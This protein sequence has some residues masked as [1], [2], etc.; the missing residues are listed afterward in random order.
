MK[1][2]HYFLSPLLLFTLS[3]CSGGGGGGGNGGPID[4]KPKTP[5]EALAKLSPAHKAN[6][7][8]WKNKIVKA[9]DSSSA[10]VNS[11]QGGLEQLGVDGAELIKANRN[12]AIFTLD[13]MNFAILSG[14]TGFSGEGTTK[15]EETTTVN[16]QSYTLQAETQREG[17]RCSLYLFGQKVH[18]TYIVEKFAVGAHYSEQDKELSTLSP[19]PIV[20]S[21]GTKSFGE[22]IRHG[23][24]D[25]LAQTMAPDKNVFSLMAK[26][27]NISEELAS[28]LFY[29]S[30]FNNTSAV[31]LATTPNS[32]WSS[33][34]F[35]NLIAPKSDLESVFSGSPQQIDLV[36][37]FRIPQFDFSGS[38]NSSDEG[39]LMLLLTAAVEKKSTEATFLYTLKH[40][41]H[42]G[43]VPYD[44]KEAE[45]CVNDRFNAY[46]FSASENKAILPS[47]PVLLGPCTTLLPGI[48]Q[49]SYNNGFFKAT[50]AKAFRMVRPTPEF[51]YGGWDEV[52]EL[53][54]VDALEQK[55]S[56]ISE[57]DPQQHT[58]VVPKIAAHLEELE[59]QLS[60][61]VNLLPSKNLIYDMGLSWVFTG[62]D[63]SAQKIKQILES[64][65]NVMD[66]FPQSGRKLMSSLMGNPD[67]YS[68][69]LSFA[70]GISLKYK[71]MALKTLALSKELNDQTFGSE[72]FNSVVQNQT[73]FQELEAWNNWFNQIKSEITK[74]PVLNPV[75]GEL[76][77]HSVKWLKNGEATPVDLQGIYAA[78]A[79]AVEPFADSTKK[80][81]SDLGQSLSAQAKALEYAQALTQEHRTLALNILANATAAEHE[82]LGR[83]LFNSI[84]QTQPT[85]AQLRLWNDLWQGING[86]VAREKARAADSISSRPKWNRDRIVEL[87]IKE[88]W[89][90]RNFLALEKIAFVA[91]AKSSCDRY[92][93][94]SSLADCAGLELFSQKTKKF[95][96]PAFSNRYD[97]LA[98]DFHK[99]M[100]R[101]KASEWFSLR[102]DLLREF[103]GP[104]EPIWS[105]CDNTIFASKATEL[106]GQVN[107]IV[108][109]R[110]TSKKWELERK[111]KENIRNCR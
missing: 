61:T 15:Y 48:E 46:H 69:Q 27:L 73:S 10:F 20:R 91:V 89:P 79:N 103:F 39:N 84:L 110:D 9:C 1:A 16:G 107:Q 45:A 64:L 23:F 8:S 93:D 35:G 26:K 58:F 14:Y 25:L 54:A 76:V 38:K 70:S 59:R 34:A 62:F 74:Y 101:L 77:A 87:A 44:Q 55:K 80:L 105:S 85:I 37:R 13:L 67:G 6:L 75:K 96:D 78:L 42:F 66:V 43:A 30:G 71:S 65:D 40:L 50:V 68:A 22:V 97:G 24:Y 2:I 36:V 12:S 33:A 47:V 56:I 28:Q 63:V 83:N 17:S 94:A 51:N 92:K 111:I 100:A 60:D 19:I 41:E 99:Y 109:E 98:D 106:R 102:S 11:S 21:I 104:W 3:A 31:R 4:G 29:L 52:L 86:F 53:L 18:E 57:L 7:E 5:E 81:V 82:N 32:V 95:F 49:V 88:V 90:A 108:S 72:I